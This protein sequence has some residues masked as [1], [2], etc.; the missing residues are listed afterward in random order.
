MHYEKEA[1]QQK[2]IIE[3]IEEEWNNKYESLRNDLEDQI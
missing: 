1:N 3:E 2:N